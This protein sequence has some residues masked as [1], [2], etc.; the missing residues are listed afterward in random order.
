MNLS[1]VKKGS[2]TMKLMRFWWGGSTVATGLKMSLK[3]SGILGFE[4]IEGKTTM[5]MSA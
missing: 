2:D 4:M 3:E 5:G 1:L